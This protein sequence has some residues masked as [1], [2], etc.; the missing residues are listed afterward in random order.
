MHITRYTDYSLR[1]LIYLALN[2]GNRSTIKD[3]ADS[4]GISK[5]HL[6]KVVHNLNK[7]GYIETLRGKKGGMLLSK[8]P[9][10]IN[11]GK[12]VLELEPDFN[13]VECFSHDGNCAI[14]S[15]CELKSILGVALSAFIKKLS[16]YT[17]ADVIIKGDEGKAAEVLGLTV[18][19]HNDGAV[20]PVSNVG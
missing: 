3:I 8:K 4:Y 12:L 5:N 11:I 15:V 7:R 2:S 1:V 9:E 17:L 16:E 18:G 20:I 6:M 14:T 10:N 19:R 13:L